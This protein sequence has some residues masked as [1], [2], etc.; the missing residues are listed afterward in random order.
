MQIKK[1]ESKAIQQSFFGHFFPPNKI[2]KEK[3]REYF[4]K[5]VHRLEKSISLL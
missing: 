3:F 2:T 5:I 1:K 4:V